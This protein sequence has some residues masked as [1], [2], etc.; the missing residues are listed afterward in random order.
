MFNI[1]HLCHTVLI[2]R[3]KCSILRIS[4]T[5][6]LL[7][8]LSVQYYAPLPHIPCIRIILGVVGALLG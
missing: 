2:K 8:G 5:L 3:I 6:F 1:T 7:K 4:A